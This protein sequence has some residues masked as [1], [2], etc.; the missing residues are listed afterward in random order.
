[1]L[2]EII[3][4]DYTDCCLKGEVLSVEEFKE[5]R[6]VLDYE[7]RKM[8]ADWFGRFVKT[9]IPYTVY[10]DAIKVSKVKD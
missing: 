10:G 1:M 5:A 9:N 7:L 2:Q 4:E 3:D 8:V 6:V